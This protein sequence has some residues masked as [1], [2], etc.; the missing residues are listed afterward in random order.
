MVM[1]KKVLVLGGNFGGLTAALI[2]TGCHQFDVVPGLDAA[3]A[4]PPGWAPRW[5]VRGDHAPAPAAR[6]GRVDAGRWQ[7]VAGAGGGP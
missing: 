3:N 2:A 1:R 4:A 5:P 6:R 7:R